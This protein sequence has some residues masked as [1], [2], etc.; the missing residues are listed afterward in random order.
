MTHTREIEQD[1]STQESAP[2]DFS[3]E[4]DNFDPSDP[5]YGAETEDDF[6]ELERLEYALPYN[7]FRIARKI[8]EIR[9]GMLEEITNTN[10]IEESYDEPDYSENQ[11]INLFEIYNKQENEEPKQNYV[12][13]KEEPKDLLSKI[14]EMIKKQDEEH[15]EQEE[16]SSEEEIKKTA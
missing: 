1:Y 16:I 12:L 2:E 14:K 4:F 11:I 13:L 7:P 9:E 3:N 15:N 10:P 8:K 5:T 6:S